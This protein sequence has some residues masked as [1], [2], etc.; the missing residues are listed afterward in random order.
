MKLPLSI[1]LLLILLS[2]CKTQETVVSES[3]SSDEL[4]EGVLIKLPE[5]TRN[6]LMSVEEYYFKLDG[7]NYFVKLSESNVPTKKL[8][9]YVD[10]NVVIEGDIKNGPWE[11]VKPASLSSPDPV[12]VARSGMYI[13]INSIKKQ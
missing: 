10:K 12:E 8:Q 5:K 9:K 6:G 1:F 7:K 2:A 3:I 11:V 13:T 4:K